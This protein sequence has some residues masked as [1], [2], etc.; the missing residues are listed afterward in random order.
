MELKAGK[1]RLAYL[2]F[3]FDDQL[4]FSGDLAGQN[5]QIVADDERVFVENGFLQ[6]TLFR[7]IPC[8]RYRLKLDGEVVGFLENYLDEN[9]TIQLELTAD[10]GEATRGHLMASAMGFMMMSDFLDQLN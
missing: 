3:H 8:G 6:R 5:L 2:T 9:D 1:E 7:F 4:V 10:L